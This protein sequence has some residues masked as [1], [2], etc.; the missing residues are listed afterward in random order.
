MSLKSQFLE[1]RRLDYYIA[2]GLPESLA[3]RLEQG[4]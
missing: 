3:Q 1:L 2:S 4:R